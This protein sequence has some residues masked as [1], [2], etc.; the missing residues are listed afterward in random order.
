MQ[1]AFIFQSKYRAT[2]LTREEWTRGPRNPLQSRESSVIRL[3]Q[4]ARKPGPQSKGKSVERR[5]S[6][7]LEKYATVFQADV[8]PIL[9]CAYEIQNKD[10]QEKCVSVCSDSQAALKAQTDKTIS[11]SVQQ[12]RKV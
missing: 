9:A 12:C 6:I 7:S 8:Y 5:P 10:R 4:D 2:M 3:V 1:P 11:L